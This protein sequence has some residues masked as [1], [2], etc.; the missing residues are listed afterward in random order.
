VI[1]LPLELTKELMFNIGGF[2]DTPQ[3]FKDSGVLFWEKSEAVLLFSNYFMA[4][5]ILR[6]TIINHQAY[7]LEVEPFRAYFEAKQ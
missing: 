5:S 7:V 1:R 4:K 3:G 6:D 2:M